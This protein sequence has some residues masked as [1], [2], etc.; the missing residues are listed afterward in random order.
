MS[1]DDGRNPPIIRS[2]TKKTIGGKFQS[3]GNKLQ[4]AD[5]VALIVRLLAEMGIP[6]S[7]SDLHSILNRH[8]V[9]FIIDCRN[10]L[11]RT[12]PMFGW[13]QVEEVVRIGKF[14]REERNKRAREARGK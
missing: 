10:K 4:Q 11:S 3:T 8:E 12:N 1:A 14:V 2:H 13:R 9:E 6:H 7:D 5:N